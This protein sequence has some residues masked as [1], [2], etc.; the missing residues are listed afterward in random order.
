MGH[1]GNLEVLLGTFKQCYG[2]TVISLTDA[3]GAFF[4]L[5]QLFLP[6]DL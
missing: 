2:V 3:H 1:L 6:R 5:S 4:A